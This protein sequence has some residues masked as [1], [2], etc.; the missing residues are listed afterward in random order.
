MKKAVSYC[1]CV[2]L[3]LLP[4]EAYGGRSFHNHY[5]PNQLTKDTVRYVRRLNELLAALRSLMTPEERRTLSRVQIRFPMPKKGDNLNNFYSLPS[6]TDPL[7]YMPLLSLKAVED[8]TTAY[9]WLQVHN[10]SQSTIDLYYMM[11]QY[12]SDDKFPSNHPQ[13]LLKALNIPEN[14][15]KNRKVDEFSLQLRNQA[16]AFIL[17]HE[18]GH[19]LYRHKGYNEIT[20]RQARLDEI[21]A[22]LFAM[23][24]L[25]RDN[26]NIPIGG[27]LYFQALA[28][29]FPHRAEFDSEDEWMNY[30][31]KQATH[32]LSVDR[33][34][35]MW[36]YAE[37]ATNRKSLGHRLKWMFM[38]NGFKQ[39]E[40]ILR[41]RP[42]HRCL[43]LI[44]INAPMDILRPNRR[45]VPNLAMT[46]K[47]CRSVVK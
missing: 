43:K 11:L 45:H 21:E 22:D 39:I 8:M 16:Y 28:Y 42:L 29:N 27:F 25:S 33:I 23:N 4:M 2:F 38:Y 34:R 37:K 14:A 6:S 10:Y 12:R 44:S 46:Q 41:D 19:I 15:N 31:H 9:A 17:A 24:L 47:Y 40:N 26:E 13:T 35:H 7:V 32:P 5:S 3:L 18:L 30:M 1:V 20:K 36:K